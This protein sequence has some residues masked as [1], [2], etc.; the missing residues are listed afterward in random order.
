MATQTIIISLF[1][2][3]EINGQALANNLTKLL[4]QY[5]LRNKIMQAYVKDEGSNLN[6]MIIV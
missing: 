3:I 5:G 2:A 1:E 6:T 4:N